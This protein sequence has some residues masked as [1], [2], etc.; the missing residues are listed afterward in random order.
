MNVPRILRTVKYIKFKQV[1]YQL[2]NRFSTVKE[3]KGDIPKSTNIQFV[4]FVYS[5][6][7]LIGKN[8]FTFLN[9]KKE[10]KEVDWNFGGY[11]KL[12]T[13]NLN[14][15][16]YLLQ[17]D[18]SQDQGEE[19]IRD[20]IQKYE[21]HKDA[22]EPYPVSLRSINWIKFFIQ[23]D[24]RNCDYDLVL[25]RDLR[26]L[27]NRVE[28]HLLGNHLLENAFA[29]LF[30]AFYFQ[31][32]HFY[33]KAKKILIAELNEQVLKDG[34]HFELSPMYHCILL[35]KVLDCYQLV[36]LNNWKEDNLSRFL[37]DKASKML[38][39]LNQIVFK[40]KSYPLLN[41]SAHGIAKTPTELYSYASKLGVTEQKVELGECGYRKWEIRNA[42]IVLD[43]GKIGPDYI[44]GHAHA[45]TFNFVMKLGDKEIISDPGIS[46]Y[47]KNAQRNLERSTLMHNTVS[48]QGENSSEV[49][50]GFRV[51]RRAQVY[52]SYEDTHRIIARHDGYKF[53]KGSHQREFIRTE[54][55]FELIDVVN[56]EAEARFILGSNCIV[57][58][59]S[60]NEYL[61]E[62]V[63]LKFEGEQLK[64]TLEDLNVPDGYN[65]Y[66]RTRVL[67]V[68]FNS[69]L[70]SKFIF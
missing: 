43:I 68:S 11:G 34:A 28:N 25:Y 9:L 46:T 54:N 16:D 69:E 10:F 23:R 48:F 60:E 3:Y 4:D 52:L 51:G 41:D 6:Q 58:E 63:K 59:L 7:S 19:L 36:Q 15:F 62:N 27:Y 45:D 31:D 2:V 14:Y 53:L 67:V 33:K 56:Q 40:D 22:R 18:I 26:R 50:G 55:S 12:W 57:Q 38:G 5:H 39:W 32:Q 44:P 61:L 1:Y 66:K 49:W 64:V 8:S 17:K 35:E 65:Q 37:L 24:I 30:G 21:G 20:F 42:E 13:Y 70:K 29:L 47:E